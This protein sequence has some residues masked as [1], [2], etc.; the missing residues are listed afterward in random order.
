MADPLTYRSNV[1]K[2]PIE[3]LSMAETTISRLS[4]LDCLTADADLFS[5]LPPP[6]IYVVLD[7]LAKKNLH[8]LNDPSVL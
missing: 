8:S 4:F 5:A 6:S 3:R 7:D 1:P 2:R